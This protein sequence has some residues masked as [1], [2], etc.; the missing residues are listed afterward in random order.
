M[1]S[2]KLTDAEISTIYSL[3]RD[4]QIDGSHYGNKEAFHKQIESIL[5]KFECAHNNAK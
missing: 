2:I 4:R 1:K 3:V 5:H